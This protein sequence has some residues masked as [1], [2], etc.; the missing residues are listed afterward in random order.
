MLR[1]ALF[2]MSAWSGE[3]VLL[4]VYWTHVVKLYPYLSIS[5][6][7]KLRNPNVPSKL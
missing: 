7:L 1:M 2:P 5:I 6:E 3:L 4:G